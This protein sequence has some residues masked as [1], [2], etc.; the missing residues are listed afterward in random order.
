[1][2]VG[3]L[4]KERML[5]ITASG[6]IVN[7]AGRFKLLI[8]IAAQPSHGEMIISRNVQMGRAQPAAL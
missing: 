5:G 6:N 3:I 4:L 8:T 2:M 1:M 7:L